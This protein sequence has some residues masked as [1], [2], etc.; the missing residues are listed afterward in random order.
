MSVFS[1]QDTEI[2]REKNSKL[3]KAQF[4]LENLEYPVITPLQSRIPR[5][6]SIAEFFQS[7]SAETREFFA[8]VESRSDLS[9][10]KGDSTPLKY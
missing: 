10:P 6:N 4:D 9:V 5:A 2:A 8:S 7:D 3:K 1:C